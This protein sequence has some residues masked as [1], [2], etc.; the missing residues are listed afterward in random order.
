MSVQ[1][2]AAQLAAPLLELADGQRVL[3][4]CAAPGGK[5]THMLELADVEL[6]ALDADAQRLERVRGESRAAGPRGAASCAATRASRRRGGMASRSTASSP[7]C[8]A[9]LRASC[10][11]IPI[12]SGCGAPDDVEQF[13][14]AQRRMLDAL[15]QLLRERW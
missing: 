6:T 4:A 8:R 1:D 14:R 13:A 7:T 11:A 9:P 10:A 12:S 5:T 2:A 3:D 15:W